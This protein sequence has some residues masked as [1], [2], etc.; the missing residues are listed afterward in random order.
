MSQSGDAGNVAKEITNTDISKM[1]KIIKELALIKDA[2]ISLNEEPLYSVWL[3]AIEFA[4]NN[5]IWEG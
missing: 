5:N 4:N 2:S 3:T 1:I